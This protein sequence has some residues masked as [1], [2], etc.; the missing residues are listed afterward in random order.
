MRLV[1]ILAGVLLLAA[2]CGAEEKSP[3]SGTKAKES[4]SL[5]FEF[6][7]ALKMQEIDVDRDSLLSAIRDALDG[8]KP[9]IAYEEMRDTLKQLRKDVLIRYNSRRQKQLAVNKDEG[10]AFL[11]DNKE[12]EGVT[13]LSSGLQ[14]KVLKEGAGPHPKAGDRVKVAYRGSL[15][16]GFVF[17]SSSER[18]GPV[19]VAVDGIIRCWAEALPLMKVGSK[20]QLF[21]PAELGYGQ[22]QY[23]KVPPNSTLIYELEL[24]SIE[25]GETGGGGTQAVVNGPESAA[26][27]GYTNK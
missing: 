6:G 1:T 9:E 14:Y 18:G 24:V 7:S 11:A 10:R 20:W 5:G 13:T 12:K 2:V 26:T 23:G 16:N 8:R 17:D 22:R 4:Y 3:A 19:T 21:V 25:K 15:I 27:G